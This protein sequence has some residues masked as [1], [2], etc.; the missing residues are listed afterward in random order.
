MYSCEAM[1]LFSDSDREGAELYLGADDLFAGSVKT[2]FKPY[3]I[4]V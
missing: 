2:N 1:A 4:A 3:D